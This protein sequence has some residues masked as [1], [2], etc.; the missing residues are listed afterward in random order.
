[1]ITWRLRKDGSSDDWRLEHSVPSETR[2]NISSSWRRARL[3]TSNITAPVF[4]QATGHITGDGGGGGGGGG[5]GTWEWTI[6]TIIVWVRDAASGGGR[7]ITSIGFQCFRRAENCL[8]CLR[9]GLSWV[10]FIGF[11]SSKLKLE[12]C[13][14]EKV[15]QKKERPQLNCK[16]A[17][18][19]ER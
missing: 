6:C 17:E 9:F 16:K 15:L 5:G 3:E 19:L 14:S 7:S 8:S 12:H 2:E 18:F 11:G 1:M 10:R 4:P 13:S